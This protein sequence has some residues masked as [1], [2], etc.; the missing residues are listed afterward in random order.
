MERVGEINVLGVLDRW[1]RL[2]NPVWNASIVENSK[3]G[4]I[5]SPMLLKP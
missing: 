2:A 5:T 1:N 4:P 3:Y